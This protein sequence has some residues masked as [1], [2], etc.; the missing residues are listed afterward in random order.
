MVKRHGTPHVHLNLS[1]ELA[2]HLKAETQL[3]LS[4]TELTSVS[5]ADAT[6]RITQPLMQRHVF[7]MLV[8]TMGKGAGKGEGRKIGGKDGKSHMLK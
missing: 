5:L 4:H 6:G 2:I 8:D 1:L 3:L 7:S